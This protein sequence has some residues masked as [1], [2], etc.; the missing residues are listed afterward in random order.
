MGHNCILYHHYC[1]SCQRM[2]QDHIMENEE[3]KSQKQTNWLNTNCTCIIIG[4]SFFYLRFFFIFP[5]GSSM[6]KLCHA[7]TAILGFTIDHNWNSYFA[8]IL[9]NEHSSQVFSQM[10]KW[11]KIII[12]HARTIWE[13]ENKSQI[14]EIDWI[15]TVIHCIKNHWIGFLC[16]CV[17]R[18]SMFF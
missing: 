17:D 16:V 13:N 9:S 14:L 18:K 5:Y 12:T 4:C 3:K 6:W 1:K 15:E 8:K 2:T 7:L 10:V 11:F